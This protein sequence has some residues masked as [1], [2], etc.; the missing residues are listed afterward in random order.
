LFLFFLRLL[1]FQ[2]VVYVV[3]VFFSSN[4]FFFHSWQT[5]IKGINRL[6]R[7]R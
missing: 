1:V 4:F 3:Y 7:Q 6:I 2:F 5:L